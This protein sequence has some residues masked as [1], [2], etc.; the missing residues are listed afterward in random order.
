VSVE[1]DLL[2]GLKAAQQQFAL[3]ALKRPVNRDNFEYGY[4]VGVVSGYEAAINLLLDLVRRE[5][6]DEK[7][8]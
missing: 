1:V 3:D 7:D 4:R 6:D 2:N 8:L 5:R